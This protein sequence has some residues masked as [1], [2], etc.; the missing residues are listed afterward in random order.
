[1]AIPIIGLSSQEGRITGR[2]DGSRAVALKG[3]IQPRALRANDRGALD[4]LTRIPYM[5]MALKPTDQ[6]AADLEQFLEAQRDPSSSDYQRWLTPEE[7]GDRFG[8]NQNDID[9]IRSWLESEG[10][11]VEQVARAR[12]W[13]AFS[14]N[15]GQVGKTFRTEMHRYQADGETHFANAT[16]PEIP[17]ALAGIVGELHGLDDFH[18][19]AP[20]KKKIVPDLTT[21]GGAHYL[22]PDDLAAIYDIS[23][24][25]KAG[26]DGTGQK[27]VIAG[28]TDI[29][30]A[31]IRGFRSTFGLVAKDPQLVL[32]GPDPGVSPEDQV[33]SDLDLEWSGAV[34]RNAT[35]IFVYSRDAFESAQYAI[36]QNL[37]PVISVSYGACELGVSASSRAAVQQANAEGITWMNS[38]G[39]SGAAGCDWGGPLTAQYGPAVSYP[40]DIPEI[41]AVGGAEFNESGS[42]GWSAQNSATMGSATSYLPERGWNDT[43]LGG[44]IWASG[45][46]ASVVFPKPWWQAGPGVPADNARDV[47]D[48]SLTASGAHDGYLIYLSGGLASVGGTSASSPSFAGIVAIVNQYVVAKG[49]QSKPGLGNINPTLYSLAQNT[50]GIIHDITVGDNIVPCTARSTGCT[51]GSFGYKAGV[52]YDL[53][54]GLGSVDAYNLVTRWVSLPATIG[55]T[56]TLTA[57]PASIAQSATTQL[58]AKITPVTG[59]TPPTGSVTFTAAGVSLGSAAAIVSGTT[60]TA[61]LSVKGSSLTGVSEAITATYTASGS[62]S[63][64]TASVTVTLTALPV[65]TKT[66]VTASAVSVAAAGTAQLTATITP[67]S[68]S[69]PPTG[70]VTFSAGA[71]ALGTVTL[72]AATAASGSAATAT[73][74]V[75]ASK[76]AAGGNSI[77]ASYV[78]AGGFT[79]SVSTAITVTV[80]TPLIATTATLAANPASIAQSASTVLTVTAKAASGSTAPTGSSTPTGSTVPTGGVTFLAG[81]TVLGTATLA[82]SAGSVTA[83]LT[84]NGSSLAGGS[85]PVTA[86]Y[87]GDSN[88]SGSTASVTVTVAG[89]PAATTTAAAASPTSIAQSATTT[90]TAMVKATTGAALPAGTVNFTLGTA[91]L[92]SATLTVTGGIAAAALSVAGSKL[93][94]GSNSITTSYVANS[95]FA[96]STG[97]V[98]VVVTAPA[99]ATTTALTASPASI[100]QSATTQLTATVKAASGSAAPAGSVTFAIGNTSLGS[101]TLTTTGATAAAVLSVAGSR[102][103]VGS[104]SITATYAGS[105]AFAVSTGSATVVVTASPV[106]TTTALVASPASIAQSAATQLTAMVK[107]ASGSSAAAGSVTFAIGNTSLGSAPLTAADG[108]AAAVL[109]VA[110][111]KLSLGSNTITASYAGN[112]SFAASAGSMTVVATAP[113]V[114]TTTALAAS[115]A[116][117]AQSA[118]TQLTATVNAASG[119]AAPVGSV[120]FSAGNVALGTAT[121]GGSGGTATASLTVKGSSLAGGSNLVAASYAGNGAFSGSTGSVTVTVAL[122]LAATTTVAAASPPTIAPNATTTVTAMVKAASGTALPAGTVSFALGNTSLGSAT[123]TATGGMTAAVLSVAGARLSVGSN[124]IT[125]SYSG[126][127]SFTASAGSVIVV[128][129]APIATATVLT[130]SSPSIAQNAPTQLT[131]TVKA[132][133]GSTAPT[134]SAAPTGSTVPTGSVT[135]TAG[136]VSLGTAVLVASGATATASLTVNGSSLVAGNNTITAS[137]SGASGF[138]ASSGSAVVA[139]AAAPSNVVATATKTTNV[140]AGFAVKL[141]LQ[142]MAGGATTL[143]GFTINGTNFMP[144]MAADFGGTQIVAHGALTSTMNIQWTPLPATLVFVFNGIDASGRQWTQTVSLATTGR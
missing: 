98:T 60:S 88:F 43:A 84:V 41:T 131:A 27:L 90:V 134:G 75:S 113:A 92:G 58:T 25:Y 102:L 2:I 143:T 8:V 100:A 107:T 73:L 52:G 96:A 44:G 115:P 11:A 136:S 126:N 129:T 16:E 3:N 112:S 9:Q 50:T 133:S 135:F 119:N 140:Q 97:S 101:A 20:R 132:A 42:A 72:G 47:P 33:E 23:A 61:T 54:T 121:L 51:T 64:S 87:G 28:Q 38:S 32:Y 105:G 68:G 34:A 62:F 138:S 13:I 39:D 78:G 128:V 6:Q 109:S 118:T 15:A 117:I 1:L 24:L 139:V 124:T 19:R 10:F 5:R 63:N 110:G 71:N 94:L 59:T 14:G 137:Y 49:V 69:V 77:T 106:A 17:Q 65:A 83:A 86:S 18:P 103:S 35:I 104:N 114:A 130:A 144:A 93:S 123:L 70:S 108:A 76:L 125:A 111:S 142:E 120:T 122:P 79:G 53:V 40:A 141:Q 66:V 95:S 12:N 55:T 57:S 99:M 36:D 22:A 116:S 85:N 81:N 56:M 74:S 26:Y 48:I 21:A 82:A 30:L 37:A 7:F 31:D 29:N 45:G 67:A 80:A 89:A 91:S 46:G 127:S 4:P